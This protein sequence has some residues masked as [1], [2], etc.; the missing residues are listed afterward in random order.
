MEIV[1]E[2]VSN[3]IKNAMTNALRNIKRSDHN[4][5]P[6][7]KEPILA[8]DI[9]R[10]IMHTPELLP[11]RCEEASLWLFALTVGA[12]AITCTHVLIKDILAVYISPVTGKYLIQINQKVVKGN[13]NANHE[14]TLE[15]RVD[16]YNPTDFVFWFNRHLKKEF[17]LPSLINAVHKNPDRKL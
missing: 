9:E 11:T 6:G 4:A 15:G 12:R 5:G 8:V 14:V 13:Y 2:T 1:K 17:G 7:G 16:I 3:D 10:V